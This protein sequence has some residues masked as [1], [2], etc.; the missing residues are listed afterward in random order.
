MTSTTRFLPMKLQK[1]DVVLCQV[2]MPS[3]QFQ[4]FKL[5]AA[6]IVSANDINQILDDVMVVPFTSNRNRSFSINQKLES[7]G[8]NLI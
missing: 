8:V 5:P 6:V 3:S 2:P 4:Q 7:L 1:G